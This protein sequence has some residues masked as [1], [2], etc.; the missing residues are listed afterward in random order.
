MPFCY[1]PWTNLDIDTRGNIG[2]CCKFRYETYDVKQ[3]NIITSDLK[4]YTSSKLL[5]DIKKNFSNDQW[6]E[7]CIRCRT[8]EENGIQSKRQLDYERWQ[9]QFNNYNQQIGGFLTASIAFGNTCNLKCITCGPGSSSRWHKE[10]KLIYNKT[11]K[12][13]HF[14]KENFIH[15]LTNS[16]PELIHLDIP[17]GEPFLSGVEQQIATFCKELDIKYGDDI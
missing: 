16:C 11:H 2:P 7:G 10:Y 15:D 13:N 14:Y 5:E 3:A 6:P 8:E 1:A 12:P 9:E 17:G 4:N